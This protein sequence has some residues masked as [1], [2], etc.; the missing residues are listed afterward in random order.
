MSEGSQFCGRSWPGQSGSSRRKVNASFGES[1]SPVHGGTSRTSIVFVVWPIFRASSSFRIH[2]QAG[3][4]TQNTEAVFESFA[5]SGYIFCWW[6]LCLKY[7]EF[8]GLTTSRCC[9]DHHQVWPCKDWRFSKWLWADFV[10]GA[11]QL[12]W[13]FQGIP[14]RWDCPA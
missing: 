1:N 12:V 3:Q 6:C 8:L 14:I 9:L 5:M 2:K 10:I 11:R 7:Q 13:V 4:Q